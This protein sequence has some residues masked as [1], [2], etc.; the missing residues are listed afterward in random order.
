M[1]H[2][3]S[4]EALG[5]SSEHFVELEEEQIRDASLMD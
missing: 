4:I 5:R 3:I 1:T 2:N